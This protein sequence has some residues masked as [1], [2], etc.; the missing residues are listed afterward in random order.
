M[1]KKQTNSKRIFAGC[2]LGF[3]LGASVFWNYISTE[4]NTKA[5]SIAKAVSITT[6]ASQSPIEEKEDKDVFSE[7][8]K[9][10]LS[11]DVGNGRFLVV[12]SH[13]NLLLSFVSSHGTNLQS[14]PLY[15][16]N[17][18]FLI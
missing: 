13:Q 9:D 18:A 15:I 8:R 12:S 6:I 2:L 16:F 14:V 3:F 4:S 10:I 5:V 11:Q 1:F 17:R 7:L